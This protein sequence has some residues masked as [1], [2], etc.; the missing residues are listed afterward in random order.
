MKEMYEIGD[1][2]EFS[3]EKGRIAV[4]V[5]RVTMAKL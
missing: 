5:N 1:L 2:F 4:S 3:F